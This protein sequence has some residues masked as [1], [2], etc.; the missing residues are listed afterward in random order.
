MVPT[1]RASTVWQVDRL[2]M[3]GSEGQFG[4]PMSLS[5]FCFVCFVDC[6]FPIFCFHF[7]FLSGRGRERDNGET[8]PL[9]LW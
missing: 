9:A 2:L 7:P 1:V 8:K 5:A 4:L 3:L 6:L